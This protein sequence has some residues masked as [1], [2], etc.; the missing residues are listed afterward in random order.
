[1]DVVVFDQE[2][3]LQQL[4]L[5]EQPPPALLKLCHFLH[6]Y[7]IFYQNCGYD[8][9]QVDLNLN[10]FLRLFISDENYHWLVERDKQ[11]WFFLQRRRMRIASNTPSLMKPIEPSFGMIRQR[12]QVVCLFNQLLM[13]SCSKVWPHCEMV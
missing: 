2:I 12:G 3:A 6:L 1:M 8:V 10:H 7:R 4:V 9:L 11:V 13:K 5:V